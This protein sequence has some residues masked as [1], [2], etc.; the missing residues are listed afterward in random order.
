MSI[1][2]FESAESYGEAHALLIS[3][4]RTSDPAELE[5]L[6]QEASAHPELC[7]RLAEGY[8]LWRLHRLDDLF[9]FLQQLPPALHQDPQYWLL[10]GLAYRHQG[11]AG[12]QSSA[13]AYARGLELAPDRSDLHY[14]LAN[15]VQDSDSCRAERHYK[16]SLEL[17][18]LQAHAWHN[19]S[20]LLRSQERFSEAW[21][22]LKA[23]L[24]LDPGNP[25]GWCNLGLVLM[26]CG[27]WNAA[28]RSFLQSLALDP[29]LIRSRVNLGALL[30]TSRRPEEALS[31]LEHGVALD[32][33]SAHPLFNLGLCHL[34]MGRFE[35]GWEYY[36]ARF[37]THLV[38]PECIPTLG[39]ALQSLSEAP[40]EG[41][42]PLVV[43]AEQGL[44]DAIQFSRYLAMLEAAGVVFEFHCQKELLRLM[45]QWFQPRVPIK[46]LQPGSDDAEQRIHCPLLSLP[47]L[48][49][50]N[51][52]K[53]PSELHYLKAPSSAPAHLQVPYSP[54]GLA[55]GLV[56]ASNADNTAMYRNKS[57]PLQLL[58]PFLLDLVELDLIDIHALQFG[59]DNHQLDPWRDHPRVI[60]W[61]P[62]LSD[63]ADTAYV[64]RQL[65]LVISV[66]TAVAHLAAA[67][68][69]PTWLL[70]CWDSDFRWLRDRNDS[71]WYPGVMRLFRQ[72]ERDDWS[73]LFTIL[74]EALDQL[75]LLDLEALAAAK[76]H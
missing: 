10:L 41:A 40:R 22:A 75:F 25:S 71:P 57:F 54:G 51:E 26:S 61:A 32:P 64:V 76:L 19:F 48:F 18:A 36:E 6:R 2:P 47:R 13:D 27:Q 74:R 11:A 38:P 52:A 73:G 65:D 3:G 43:W 44:G 21:V 16:K 67:L 59:P 37:R 68:K 66:D 62:E 9:D 33:H 4:E 35:T 63:L 56:W 45:E 14:N 60:D 30:V 12:E 7:W 29:T 31:H 28:E 39:P 34:L 23:S 24:Q 58:M 15:L 50:T 20:S 49:K 1:I 72:P 70:L 69:C 42:D 17:D 55:V 8:F 5:S 46:L 53:I